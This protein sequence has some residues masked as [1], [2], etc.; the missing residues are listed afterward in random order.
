MLTIGFSKPK[1]FKPVSLL[2][3]LLEKTKFSHVYVKL[4]DERIQTWMVYEASGL[5][6]HCSAE[7]N[8]YQKNEPIL[9]VS[10]ECQET[11]FKQ[12]LK[13]ANDNLNIDY[14]IKQLFGMALVRIAKF[15]GKTI[16]N[17]FADGRKTYV[18]SEYAGILLEPLG[19]KLGNLDELTPRDLYELL[20][21]DYEETKK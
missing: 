4:Y 5:I 20:W 2:I 21:Q 1:K 10:L 12:I 7:N 14:G 16:K 15:F 18:C 11:I 13:T 19:Y 9:E 3:R 6:T 17:P 8:F